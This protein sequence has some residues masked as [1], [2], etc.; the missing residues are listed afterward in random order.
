ML[1]SSPAAPRRERARFALV[2]LTVA[3]AAVAAVAPGIAGAHGPEGLLTI[4]AA[5]QVGPADPESGATVRLEVGIVYAN[6][7]DPAE[8]AAVA[9]TITGE[10]GAVVGP[11]P[12]PNV[13]GGVYGAEVTVPTTGRWDIE[14][15]STGPAASSTAALVIA[16][17]APTTTTTTSST[18][19]STTVADDD[20]D[21][22]GSTVASS[23]SD[24]SGGISSGWLLAI[25]LGL[26]LVLAA[27]SVP[28]IS[29]LR[30]RS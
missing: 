5:E 18:T 25:G 2:A 20:A 16:E 24:E 30:G 19:T 17:P 13:N 1:P 8:E 11:T 6:D 7:N 3:I 4:I 26:L 22:D 27:A 12:L 14:V 23:A 9:A 15:T 28:V 29:R 21:G 10:G